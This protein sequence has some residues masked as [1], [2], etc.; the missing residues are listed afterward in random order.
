M[1]LTAD[2]D[3]SFFASLDWVDLP[4]DADQL[5]FKGALVGRNRTTGYARPLVAGDDFLGVAYARC[6]NSAA[7]SVAGG[8]RVR[9]H[10]SVDIVHAVSGAALGDLGR[11]VFASDD[12]TL[13]LTPSGNSRIGR[14]VAFDSAAAVRVRCEPVSASDVAENAPIVALADASATLTLDQ[15]NRVLLMGNTAARTLNLPAVATCRA[16]CWFVLVKTSAA[17]FAITLDG[18]A[19][20]TIDGAATFAG[21]DAQYDTVVVLCTGSEWVIVA[22]DIA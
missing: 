5:I 20:E 17:A 11:P 10:Q 2:R 14:V 9:V 19:G 8:K 3:V 15:L 4:V 7:D 22:R 18:N 6:D 1:A 21:V 13:T 16:G 12:G